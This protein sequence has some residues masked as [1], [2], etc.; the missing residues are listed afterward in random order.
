MA[1]RVGVG[2]RVRRLGST[3]CALEAWAPQC[4]VICAFCGRHRHKVWVCAAAIQR[5]ALPQGHRRAVRVGTVTAKRKGRGILNVVVID[6]CPCAV[7]SDTIVPTAS[8][9]SR[10][11]TIRK[12]FPLAVDILVSINIL[13]NLG[14]VLARLVVKAAEALVEMVGV[15]VPPA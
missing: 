12:V 13:S 7:R 14:T 2:M 3:S 9:E 8:V 1:H 4:V 6:L 11:H 10:K 5:V 15:R